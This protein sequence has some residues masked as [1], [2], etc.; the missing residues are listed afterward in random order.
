MY[1]SHGQYLEAI[2]APVL[3][4][5]QN[6]ETKQFGPNFLTRPEPPRVGQKVGPKI[7]HVG[8]RRRNRRRQYEAMI[9]V[10]TCLWYAS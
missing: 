10:A 8:L 5:D 7:A 3:K 6:A 4:L 2:N 9:A 1:H